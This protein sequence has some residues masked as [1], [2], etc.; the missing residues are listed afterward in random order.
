MQLHQLKPRYK[1]KKRKRI[2]RGGKRGTYSGRGNKGQK[3]R[4]GARFQPLVREFFKKYPKLR[5]YKFKKRK[6]KLVEIN[7]E[8]LEKKL[9]AGE[10]I[11]PELLLEKGLIRKKSGEKIKVKI[12]GKGK[13]NKSFTIE[14]C[15]ISKQA[16]DKIEK[17]GGKVKL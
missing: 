8:D 9:E 7:L 15:L 5:G 6:V 14:N 17:V 4:A 12:L 16:R 2:G 3:S 13:L 1:S 11:T 10:K